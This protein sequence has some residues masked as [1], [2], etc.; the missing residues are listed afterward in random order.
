MTA[1]GGRVE[2]VVLNQTQPL[3][4]SLLRSRHRVH[5]PL[6]FIV[7]FICVRPVCSFLRGKGQP[8]TESDL[9]LS[10]IRNV[11]ANYAIFTTLSLFIYGRKLM[12]KAIKDPYNKTIRATEGL[13]LSDMSPELQWHQ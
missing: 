9:L 8:N 7:L 12:P 4:K 5:P 3:S 11:G 6:S 10:E 2:A 1:R 13:Y